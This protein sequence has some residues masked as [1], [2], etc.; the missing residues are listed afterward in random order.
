MRPI[1]FAALIALSACAA[2][3]RPACGC[4][5]PRPDPTAPTPV[6]SPEAEALLVIEALETGCRD[7]G[8]PAAPTREALSNGWVRV[9]PATP[10]VPCAV[11]VDG[12]SARIT[13][14]D[15]ALLAHAEA[16]DLTWNVRDS[17]PLWTDGR[18]V[19]RRVRGENGL[20]EPEMGWTFT[21]F[22]APSQTTTTLRIEWR[23]AT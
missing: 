10:Y 7:M 21:Q 4:L 12:P 6:L 19:V 13:A 17:Y 14:V 1:A 23:P 8:T 22:E 15:E 11:E 2:A 16:M 9:I 5:P 20:G 18:R 3:P